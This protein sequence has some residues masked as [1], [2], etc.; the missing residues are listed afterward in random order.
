MKTTIR[1]P[2]PP[3]T[4]NLFMTT[5]YGRA[6][7]QKYDSWIMEAGNEIL[8]QRPPKFTGPVVLFF[9]FQENRKPRRPRDVTNLIKAP[10]DLLVKHGIIE[11]DD[12][13]IV[14]GIE[15][16]WA[17][18]AEGCEVTIFSVPVASES[19]EASPTQRENEPLV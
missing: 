3:S 12:N 4:N 16:Y 9:H 15:A 2:F 6:R 1:L 8:R 7:T 13:S 14:R 10:E 11:A 18:T 17:D 19:V 5:K